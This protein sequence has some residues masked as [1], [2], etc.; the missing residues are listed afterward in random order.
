M[1]LQILGEAIADHA[2]AVALANV[3]ELSRHRAETAKARRAT[4]NQHDEHA[5]P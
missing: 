5:A 2:D 1:Q 3:I 4:T